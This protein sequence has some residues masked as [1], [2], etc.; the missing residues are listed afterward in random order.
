MDAKSGGPS[1][2]A[3]VS[4]AESLTDPGPVK[5]V[6][7]AAWSDGPAGYRRARSRSVTSAKLMSKENTRS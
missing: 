3:G 7:V 6:K 2:T 1:R 5:K 4:A